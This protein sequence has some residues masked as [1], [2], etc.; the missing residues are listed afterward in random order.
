MPEA[1]TLTAWLGGASTGC[2]GCLFE[3]SIVVD[4]LTRQLRCHGL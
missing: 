3:K 1:R 2:M 4:S